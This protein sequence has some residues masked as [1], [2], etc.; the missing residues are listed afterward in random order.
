M[1]FDSTVSVCISQ[2]I[3][4]LQTACWKQL[5]V[6]W[7][8]W[9]PTLQQTK[10]L[11][12]RSHEALTREN[13]WLHGEWFD[14]RPDKASQMVQFEAALAGMELHTSLPPGAAKD[15]VQKLFDSRYSTPSGMRGEIER[16]AEYRGYD[17][18]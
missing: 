14:L 10:E 6:K 9:L 5:E 8:A 15:F 7:C 16:H 18:D 3:S 11:E 4:S 12:R 13:R 17:N 1:L 2:R